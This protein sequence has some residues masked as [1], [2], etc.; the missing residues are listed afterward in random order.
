LH[1]KHWIAV[2]LLFYAATNGMVWSA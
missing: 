2:F 1:V